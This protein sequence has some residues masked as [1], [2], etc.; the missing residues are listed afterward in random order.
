MN[1]VFAGTPV[2]AAQALQ[3]ILDAGFNVPL[4]LTQP[5]RPSGRGMKLTPSPVKQVALAHNIAVAQPTSLKLDGKYPA[6]AAAARET[7]KSVNADVMVVAAYGLILPTDV[8]ETPTHGCLNIH[9]SLLPRW[10]GAAPIHRAIEA[11]DAAT[12]IT[13]MQMDAGLDTGDMLAIES[14]PITPQHTTAQLHDELAAMGARMVVNHL[15]ALQNGTAPTGTVQP[16]EGVNYASKID[17][18]ESHLNWQDS[19]T[20]LERKVR[21][22]DPAPGCVTKVDEHTSFKV[23]ATQV[24]HNDAHAHPAGTVLNVD[25]HGIDVACGTGVLR[26]TQAQ[27]AGAKRLPVAQ[28]LDGFALSAG[29]QLL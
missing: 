10:R 26:I 13:L 29:M 5:D 4:V 6:E 24:V 16:S 14:L 25:K 21:A 2:F 3:A 18:T 15:K 23:W 7:L 28:F 9:A 19:A 8:L 1:I 27:K 12:G 17:K 22:F 20:T 11:G